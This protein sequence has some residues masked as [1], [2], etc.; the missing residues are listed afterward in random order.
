MARIA[1]ESGGLKYL[2]EFA[3]DDQYEGRLDLG[4]IKTGDGRR[5]KGGGARQ[6][7]GRHNY[8]A[9]C[10]YLNNP[11]VMEGCL[12]SCSRFTLHSF[13]LLVDAKLYK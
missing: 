13:G 11:R 10:N 5:Y 6:V 9:L 7:T 4:N 12:S 1:H 8:Q 3:S 2:K